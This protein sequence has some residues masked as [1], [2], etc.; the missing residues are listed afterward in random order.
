MYS[1]KEVVIKMYF[2]RSYISKPFK[3]LQSLY[4]GPVLE[5][6]VLLQSTLNLVND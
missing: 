1:N 4:S 5:P 6:G 2:A 3:K